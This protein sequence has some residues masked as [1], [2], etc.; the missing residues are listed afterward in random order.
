M[1]RMSPATLASLRLAGFLTLLGNLT[2]KQACVAQ[3]THPTAILR[4]APA[5]L[6]SDLQRQRA[7]R[8]SSAGTAKQIV[9]SAP[10]DTIK[11]IQE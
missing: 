3:T 7:P 1:E 6:S 9:R 2:Q 4:V 8:A 11:R 10:K 5:Q